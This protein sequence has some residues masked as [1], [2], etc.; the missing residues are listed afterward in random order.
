VQVGPGARARRE[1]AVCSGHDIASA[2]ATE[3]ASFAEKF[4][5][6]ALGMQIGDD[7]I[8]GDVEV[9]KVA[10]ESRVLRP[11]GNFSQLSYRK[12]RDRQAGARRKGLQPFADFEGHVSKVERLHVAECSR[13]ASIRSQE[14]K[15]TCT[16]QPPLAS[17]QAPTPTS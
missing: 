6:S 14:L 9:G 8:G 2:R 5:R 16:Q 17:V 12:G 1:S 7:R 13:D 10:E 15:R 11:A 3:D 4:C